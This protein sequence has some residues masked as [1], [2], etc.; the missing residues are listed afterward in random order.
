V[1]SIPA[2]ISPGLTNI[3]WTNTGSSY[4]LR[5]DDQTTPWA[6]NCDIAQYGGDICNNVYGSNSYSYN[7]IAGH[8]YSIW[9]HAIAG[10]GA[11]S[12]PGATT[13]SVPVN[14]SGQ[15]YVDVN[16]NGKLDLPPTTDYAYADGASISICRIQNNNC[17][18]Y[19]ILN[20]KFTTASTKSLLFG[21]YKA[22]L[23][24]ALPYKPTT[25][26]SVIFTVGNASSTVNS[27]ATPIGSCDANAN[28]I[29]L[30][31]GI[32]DSFVWMQ[33]VGGDITGTAI[34]DPNQG[35]FTNTIPTSANIT[36]GAC[37]ASATGPYTMINGAGGTH[38][39]IN[40]G[41]KDATF[42]QGQLASAQA[43][44][45]GGSAGNSY[46]YN[47][48]LSK[49]TKTA[50]ANL[51]Y[52]VGQSDIAHKSLSDYCGGGG[53]ANCQLPADTTTIPPGASTGFTSGVYTVDN[54][55]LT[56]T[57]SG[58]SYTFPSG[59]SYVILV[60]GDLNINTNIHV[61]N[62]S[63]VLFS[64]SGDINVAATVG[65][66]YNIATSNLEGYYS[67]D[68]SFNILGKNISGNGANCATTN[69]EDLRLNV[70]GSIIINASTINGG[71]FNYSQRDMCAYDKQCPVFTIS[72]RPD[73][74]LNSPTFLM[75]PRRVWQEVA[76]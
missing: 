73:F 67:T 40:T 14:A 65:D 59:G 29:N 39:L 27:C 69:N 31:F 34:S 2:T 62:G 43:W 35:G 47:M 37:S 18:A 50:Y 16:K 55:N 1:V 8:T 28:V 5:I 63:F 12:A 23:N 26:L 20:G 70:A 71:S 11:W 54:N 56:L 4:A 52:L 68:K 24:V 60:N 74:I 10:C 45:V 38:G 13:T 25:P 48:P 30:N 44:L 64:A 17:T 76:P 42:G 19:E 36:N 32:T 46:T 7:F 15:V 53:L 9:V 61:P 21:Q 3:T 75:F 49:Q 33:A 57:S 58:I 6:N 41:F 72:E 51:S 66:T 22:T